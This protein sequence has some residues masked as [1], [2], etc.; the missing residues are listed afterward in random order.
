MCTS[1]DAGISPVSSAL[2]LAL[3]ATAFLTAVPISEDF[4]ADYVS[5]HGDLLAQKADQTL[6]LEFPELG[7][8]AIRNELPG[9]VGRCAGL[10]N[11]FGLQQR[12]G[13]GQKFLLVSSPPAAVAGQAP[14]EGKEALPAEARVVCMC[15][16]AASE[17]AANL[18]LKVK[19]CRKEVSD[20]IG[21]QLAATFRELAQGRLRATGAPPA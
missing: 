1:P 14:V 2:E 21:N 12:A 10:C 5:S 18:S 15:V 19:S 13:T 20:D 3:P 8:E 6:R 9:L 11:F 4:I 17:G 7:E 16:L